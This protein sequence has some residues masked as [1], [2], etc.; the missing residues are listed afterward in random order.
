MRLFPE[1]HAQ[2][3]GDFC[4]DMSKKSKTTN[5]PAWSAPPPT[6]ATT[7]LQTMVGEGVDYSTPIRNAYARERDR[8]QRSYQHPLGP[9]TTADVQAKTMRAE[10]SRMQ[11]NMG[12]DLANAAI[13][14]QA[15]KFGQQ[16]QVAGLTSP[17]MYNAQSV[18]KQS[19]PFGTAMQVASLGTSAALGGSGKY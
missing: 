13:Q 7:N 15:A 4:F 5:T 18:T 11:Q 17:Q 19:D 12:M 14:S 2:E 3:A 8:R 1:L 9:R 10:D 16:A 6:Q